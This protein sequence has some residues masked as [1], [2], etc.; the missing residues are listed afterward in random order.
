MAPNLDLGFSEMVNDHPLYSSRQMPSQVQGMMYSD[1]D[2]MLWCF[3]E[4]D[5]PGVIYRT[6]GMECLEVCSVAAEI[7]QPKPLFGE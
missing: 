3:R 5:Y 1:E 6:S 4:P 7:K 2:K